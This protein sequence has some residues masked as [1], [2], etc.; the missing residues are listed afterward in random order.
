MVGHV[1]PDRVHP[2]GQD[3]GPP[4]PLHLP[5]IKSNR[6]SWFQSLSQALSVDIS[7]FPHLNHLPTL[8]DYGTP[9]SDR[10]LGQRG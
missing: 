5:F 8:G 6:G 3:Q 1:D 10:T 4:S 7:M 2:Q 9:F